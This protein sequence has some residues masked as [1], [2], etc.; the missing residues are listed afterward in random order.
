MPWPS[1][2][3]ATLKCW[4]SSRLLIVA[5]EAFEEKNDGFSRMGQLLT[6]PM[7]PVSGWRATSVREWLAN[8]SA[9]SGL[10]IPL[11]WAHQIFYLWG[12]L[13]D[14]VYKDNPR[15]IYEL[16]QAITTT[17][18]VMFKYVLSTEVDIW[19][20]WSA[21]CQAKV[22]QDTVLIF[23]IPV[24]HAKCSTYSWSLSNSE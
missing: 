9:S 15:S 10:H 11:I 12:Y 7:G 20:T 14:S 18:P 13:K 19:S 4:M 21:E 6:P 1:T 24:S 16:K 8:A 5:G 2:L 3:S 17:S 23:G 22:Q